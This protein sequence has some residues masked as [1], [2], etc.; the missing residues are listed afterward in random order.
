MSNFDDYWSACKK[1]NPN[2]TE[3]MKM[4]IGTGS[5]RE[6]LKQA[7]LQGA[8]DS[9]NYAEKL[10]KTNKKED[11]GLGGAFDMFGDMFNKGK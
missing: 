2:M 11:D 4:T 5:F 8:N 1:K 6:S 3:G 9:R 10:N 7:Y